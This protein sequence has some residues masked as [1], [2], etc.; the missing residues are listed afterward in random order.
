[1]KYSTVL[2]TSDHAEAAKR[3]DE[4]LKE[5]RKIEAEHPE[6]ERHCRKMRIRVRKAYERMT[7]PAPSIGFPAP[8]ESFFD[9]LDEKNAEEQAEMDGNFPLGNERDAIFANRYFRVDQIARFICGLADEVNPGH[10]VE[11]AF[12][13]IIRI[14]FVEEMKGN[15]AEAYR[16]YGSYPMPGGD[17]LDERMALCS[18]HKAHGPEKPK[19]EMR[20]K[21]E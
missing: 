15:Y 8:D 21:K 5:Y 13:V 1:M 11:P 17:E 3:R 10:Y 16:I 9:W 6:L 18:E 7:A 12:D 2:G 14:A 20:D 19:P 4:F